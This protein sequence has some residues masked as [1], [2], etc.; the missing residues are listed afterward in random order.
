MALRPEGDRKDLEPDDTVVRFL[1]LTYS[2]PAAD[3]NTKTL[4][5]TFYYLLYQR[6]ILENPVKK[7][8]LGIP[9]RS[10]YKRFGSIKINAFISQSAI[11]FPVVAFP[12]RFPSRANQVL[13]NSHC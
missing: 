7:R 9:Y 13:R 3:I 10:G 6:R 2:S 4:Q 12:M 1:K 5:G 11:K 8:L